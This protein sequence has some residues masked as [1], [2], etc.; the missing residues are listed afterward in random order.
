MDLGSAFMMNDKMILGDHEGTRMVISEEPPSNS[1]E[2]EAI[3][4]L[5]ADVMSR[6][7]TAIVIF[8]EYGGKDIKDFEGKMH[9]LDSHVIAGAVGGKITLNELVR[10]GIQ[11]LRDMLKRANNSGENG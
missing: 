3:E 7:P 6:K 10:S 11:Q 4:K 2:F 1:E 5:I 9:R 8:A